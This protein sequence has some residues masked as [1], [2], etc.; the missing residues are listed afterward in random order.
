MTPNFRNAETNTFG[1]A[2][3]A[4]SG[5]PPKGLVAVAG[6]TGKRVTLG[7]VAK[8]TGFTINTVS[9][10]LRDKEDISL[11]TRVLIQETAERMGYVRN[12]MASSLRSG[13]TRTLG[14]IM[15]GL[16]NPYYAIMANELG[17]AAEKK[18]YTIV[19][20]SSR[21]DPM[22]ELRMT[23]IA[24]G[25]Q[26]DG[27]LLFPSRDA[28]AAVNRMRE[29]GMPY[30]VL[31][32]EL[33][34]LEADTVRGDDFQGARLAAEHLIA[35]GRRRLAY[36]GL[37]EVPF[38]TPQRKAGFLEACREAGIPESDL[39][40]SSAEG[41][42][43][44]EI[45]TEWIREGVDGLFAFCDA[46]AW[47]AVSVMTELGIRIPDGLAVVGF[48][49]IQDNLVFPWPICSVGFDMTLFAESAIRMIR[50]KIHHPDSHPE[51]MVLPCTLT[52]RHSCGA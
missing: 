10:A 6:R 15:G 25:H 31:A 40:I 27:V 52:C 51:Q 12:I 2:P 45:L 4:C 9:H 11:E 33:P 19:V 3:K 1:G 29:A 30:V 32:R 44:R 49:N 13:R 23:N 41:R 37:E 20:L 21:D 50:H 38:S 39:R 36:L 17:Q 48:D 35:A 8:A 28:R 5:F 47:Q 14:L 46:E 43:L 7:D 42:P 26:M 18:G 16:E 22:R 34:H 24:I